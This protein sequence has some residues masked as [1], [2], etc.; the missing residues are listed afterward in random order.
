MNAFILS[1][2]IMPLSGIAAASDRFVRIDTPSELDRVDPA[3][4]IPVSGS[5]KGLFEGNV[6]I[7]I[8]DSDGRQLAQVATTMRRDDIAAEGT[9]QTRIMIPP[10][11]P[12]EVRLIAFSPSPKEGDAAITSKPVLLRTTGPELED[13][14]W[15]LHQYLGEAGEMMPVLPETTVDARFSRGEIGGGA[16]CNRYFGRYSTGP[17]KRLTL[18][19]EIGSTQMACPPAIARQEQYYFALLSL[20]AAWQ[21]QDD[22][23]L[24]LN[25][26]RQPILKY[27]AAGA[28]AL[29]DLPWQASGINN[30]RGGVV[31][32]NTTQLATALF[33]NG[34]ISGSAGCNQFTAAYEIKGSQISIGRTMTTRKHCAAPDGVME[35]E[36]QY[37]QALARA[38]TYTLKPDRLELRD[39][40]GSLQVSYS[41]EK[42]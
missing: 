11:V 21:R 24:L 3:K 1:I 36:Q 28:A 17:D 29:E 25:N 31:S 10:P 16:G 39:K 35:Q 9:W 37:L 8:E 30:G 41:V 38:H 27:A 7:R 5:G 26:D 33:A 23:L 12:T 34:R 19:S 14:D 2:I 18:T 42:R 4:P 22:S 15:Q 40:S 32:S 20:V 6:V 13:I